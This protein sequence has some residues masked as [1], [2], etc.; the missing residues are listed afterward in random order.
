MFCRILGPIR[1]RFGAPLDAPIDAPI[2]GLFQHVM[3]FSFQHRALVNH[4]TPTLQ[5]RV[6]HKNKA[7]ETQNS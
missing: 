1:P 6:L 4:R 3:A 5:P 7:M 2:H